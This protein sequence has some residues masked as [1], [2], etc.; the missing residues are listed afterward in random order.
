MR[1]IY[2]IEENEEIIAKDSDTIPQSYIRIFEL[3]DGE[4]R[5]IFP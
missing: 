4:Y 3:I 1:Y 5:E 2:W